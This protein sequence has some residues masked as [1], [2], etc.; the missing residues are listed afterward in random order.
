MTNWEPIKTAP[1]SEITDKYYLVVVGNEVT[2]GW[3]A[4]GV[5]HE[6]NVHDYSIP[7]THWMPLPTP[8]SK[9]QL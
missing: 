7:P 4:S 8:P 1:N 9:E 6:I 5:W 2:I 3:N